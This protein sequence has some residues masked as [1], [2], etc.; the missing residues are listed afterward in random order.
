MSYG[1][2]ALPDGLRRS[3]AVVTMCNAQVR[4]A[5]RSS[6]AV[7]F[8]MRL[9]VSP[10]RVMNTYWVAWMSVSWTPAG[11]LVCREPAETCVR[12]LIRDENEERSV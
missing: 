3:G 6:R 8:G 12:R 9:V 4:H 1:E 10:R 11:G 7:Q 2:E 5:L